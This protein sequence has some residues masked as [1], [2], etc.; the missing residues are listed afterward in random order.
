MKLIG[1]DKLQAAGLPSFFDLL[2]VIS[3]AEPVATKALRR[4][5]TMNYEAVPAQRRQERV[6]VRRSGGEVPAAKT[7]S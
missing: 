6:R 4:W 3:P 1:I 7:S 5:M 2:T